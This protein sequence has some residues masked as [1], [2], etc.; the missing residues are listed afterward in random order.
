MYMDI[1]E[2][3]VEHL[4]A[5]VMRLRLMVHRVTQVME[6]PLPDSH[7]HS[8]HVDPLQVAPLSTVPSSGIPT[9]LKN[10]LDSYKELLPLMQLLLAQQQQQQQ[11]NDA[12]LSH[13]QR[14]QQ[15]SR[16]HRRS[17]RNL[18]R[19]SSRRAASSN[20]RS[21]S[22]AAPS[23]SQSK[24]SSD[25]SLPISSSHNQ[26]N[27]PTSL[28]SH[29]DAGPARTSSPSFISSSSPTPAVLKKN[30]HEKRTE[31]AMAQGQGETLFA[32][33]RRASEDSLHV[34]PTREEPPAVTEQENSPDRSNVTPL[35]TSQIRSATTSLS[36]SKMHRTNV[37][38]AATVASP[39]KKVA[40]ATE[41]AA[42]ASPPCQSTSLTS[43]KLQ[44]APSE[45]EVGRR[46][47]RNPEEA[48][49]QYSLPA[50][51]PG[52]EAP[53]TLSE[54]PVSIKRASVQTGSLQRG[55]VASSIIH[56]EQGIYNYSA[57]QSAYSSPAL[58]H[59]PEGATAAAR[60]VQTTSTPSP[61]PSVQ[62]PSSQQRH[63]QLALQTSAL[64]PAHEHASSPSSTSEESTEGDAAE[65]QN[66]LQA[67]IPSPYRAGVILGGRQPISVRSMSTSSPFATASTRVCA[68]GSN[69]TAAA[70]LGHDDRASAAS[71]ANLLQALQP[72]PSDSSASTSSS[73]NIADFCH[74][75]LRQS[76]EAHHRDSSFHNYSDSASSQPPSQNAGTRNSEGSP[77]D[78]YASQGQDAYSLASYSLQHSPGQRGSDA[79]PNSSVG[80]LGSI[81]A[82]GYYYGYNLDIG[83]P[84]L[85]R[86][87][88]SP[89][90]DA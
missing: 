8:S 72:I 25:A 43:C 88:L 59:V 84:S 53:S 69:P 4:S 68:A 61:A 90:A 45:Q 36:R 16:R 38:D 76:T 64:S 81:S 52:R 22:H 35:A 46:A 77:A 12:E 44:L 24:R 29:K 54:S 55:S 14:R 23:R 40:P 62:L 73:S 21:S 49:D 3:E 50:F 33:E 48:T 47:A 65:L 42:A 63:N 57:L 79:S 5:E 28:P 56:S 82:G 26:G 83:S 20:S 39:R 11:R 15:S 13:G 80:H 74:P 58:S 78:P 27:Q 41:P 1:L 75:S 31:S 60:A 18:R 85:R 19:A 34:T 67:V 30:D 32:G 7:H 37:M 17:R 71:R 2:Q 89:I 70:I 51:S 10:T 9:D 86:L 66:A 87:A 6:A